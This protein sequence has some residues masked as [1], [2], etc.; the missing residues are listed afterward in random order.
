ML[1]LPP[2]GPPLA[3]TRKGDHRIGIGLIDQREALPPEPA[4]TRSGLPLHPPRGAVSCLGMFRAMAALAIVALLPLAAFASADSFRALG[5]IRS[6]RSSAAFDAVS[7]RGPHVSVTRESDGRWVGWL[8]NRVIDV[9]EVKNGVRGA[10]VALYLARSKDSST[11][12]GNLG[13]RTVSI[14]IPDEAAQRDL[15]RWALLG[16]AAEKDP[17]IPQFIFAAVAALD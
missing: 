2:D 17:P 12:R 5:E 14:D 8:G 11:V 15:L 1:Q 6:A 10:N 7:V 16:L 3:S 4:R 9:R 13:D